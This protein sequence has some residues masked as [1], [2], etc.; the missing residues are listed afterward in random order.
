MPAQA[1]RASAFCC[2]STENL[3]YVAY[4]P[5]PGDLDTAVAPSARKVTTR[6]RERALRCLCGSVT[7]LLGT[8]LLGSVTGVHAKD[9]ITWANLHFPPWM[10]L[11][12]ESAGQ[13]VWDALLKEVIANLP[14][15]DHEMVDMKNVRYEELA[16][17]QAHVCKVYYFKTP[18]REEVLHYSV[19]SVVFLANYVVMRNE[20]ARE[21]GNPA[22]ISLERLLNDTR[23]TGTFIA[24]R[25]YGKEIDPLLQKHKGMSHLL[26]R[27]LD[28]QNLFEVLGLGRTDY[29]LEFPAVR[30]FFEHDLDI[31]PAVANISIEGITPYN[32]TYVTCVK[33]EWGKRVIEKVDDILKRYIPTPAHREATLRWYQPAE[34]IE[35]AKYYQRILVEP[36]RAEKLPRKH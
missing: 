20:K 5:C 36:L 8:L 26:F 27:V 16:R 28:N 33:N 12:G 34:Q 35:L 1:D 7:A 6:D 18:E 9:T 19:P 3:L 2:L 21:L 32:V 22:S 24:G 25:S 11:K 13:G 10:I 15:Y 14:E 17:Q 23:F 30:S 4:A 31:H 29:I